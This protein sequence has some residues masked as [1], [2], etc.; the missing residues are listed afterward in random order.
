MSGSIVN[1]LTPN[2]RRQ[3]IKVQPNTALLKVCFYTFNSK[4]KFNYSSE[5]GN[6]RMATGV[7]GS[8]RKA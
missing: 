7:G 6:F 3:N 8:V 2:G 5:G 1:V 4:L